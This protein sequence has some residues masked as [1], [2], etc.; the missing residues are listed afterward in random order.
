MTGVINSHEIICETCQLSTEINTLKNLA[1]EC[2]NLTCVWPVVYQNCFGKLC[3]MKKGENDQ[4]PV[5]TLTQS[6]S[7]LGLHLTLRV[8]WTSMGYL[9][10]G[11]AH[12]RTNS[13]V[14]HWPGREIA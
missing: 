3:D 5:T 4:S 9:A 10:V 6:Q 7:S 2:L 11:T 14:T 1:I 12:T 8:G 13:H